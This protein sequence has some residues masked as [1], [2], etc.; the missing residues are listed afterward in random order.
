MSV[1]D[2]LADLLPT[3]AA[4]WTAALTGM[5][6]PLA[7]A[8]PHYLSPLM[9]KSTEAEIVLEQILAPTLIALLGTLAVLALVVRAYHAQNASHA[10]A[11][12]AEREKTTACNDVRLLKNGN[13][14]EPKER[15]LTFL[16]KHHDWVADP[17]IASA[18]AIDRALATF[19]LVELDSAGM[20][21]TCL[22]GICFDDY[23]GRQIDQP[24]LAYLVS[25]GH[26]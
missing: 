24:G 23:L 13:L 17:D 6:L 10:A 8:A 14:E 26:L 21:K 4:R 18:L 12:A 20:I 15:I 11:L 7:F 5:L 2:E 22:L 19:H 25:H 1:L 16:S 3:K 9:P